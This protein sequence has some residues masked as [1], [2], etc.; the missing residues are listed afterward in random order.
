MELTLKQKAELYDACTELSME[1]P[2][3][4]EVAGFRWVLKDYPGLG[5]RMIQLERLLHRKTGRPIDLRTQE[6]SD[7]NKRK[8]MAERRSGV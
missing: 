3:L 5:P 2:E 7:G 6:I 4:V 8:E 1:T